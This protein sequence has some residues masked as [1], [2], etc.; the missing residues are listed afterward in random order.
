MPQ[1]N[2]AK[3][4]NSTE[5]ADYRLIVCEINKVFAAFRVDNVYRI[6]RI[7]WSRMEPPPPFAGSESIVG[8]VKM[9]DKLILLLDFERILA[10]V[11]PEINKKLSH[12]PHSE[13]T[14]MK[15]RGTKT[16]LIAE[17]SKMLRDLLINT[18]SGAGFHIIST[19]NGQLAWDKLNE[20]GGRI[21]LLITDIEMP[22]MDGHHL[23]KRVKTSEQFKQLPVIIFSS[24]I[25]EEMRRKGEALGADAQITKPEIGQLIDI[26]DEKVNLR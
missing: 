13:A 5:D 26:V 18:L 25:N 6:H 8:I 3:C 14:L 17:D 11:N 15:S 2:L 21:D 23:T 24:L 1:V 19:E 9:E 22:Q 16:I 4:L 10:E 7:S 20:L 12:V